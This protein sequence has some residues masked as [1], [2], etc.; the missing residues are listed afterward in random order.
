MYSFFLA[1]CDAATT[2]NGNGACNID[3]GTCDCDESYYGIDCSG[4]YIYITKND[5]ELLFSEYCLP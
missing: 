2:C 5:P 4:K 1:F 3:D